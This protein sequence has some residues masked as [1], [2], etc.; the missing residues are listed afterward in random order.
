MAY[1]LEFCPYTVPFPIPL[2]THYGAWTVREGIFLRL[3]SE[4]G[5]VGLGEIAPLPDFGSETVAQ[6]LEFCALAPQEIT[7]AW[8]EQIP[9]GLPATQ[10]GVDQARLSVESFPSFRTT[11]FA[12]AQLL[13]AGSAL[14][15]QL[16][17]VQGQPHATWKWKI[18]VYPLQTELALLQAWG[19]AL[20]NHGVPPVTLRLDANGGLSIVEAQAWLEICDR[21]NG[22]HGDGTGRLRIEFLEQ[23]LPPHQFHELQAL[24]QSY[25]TPIALDE[26]VANLRSF[27]TVIE[28]GWSGLLVIKPAIMGRLSTLMS[29][30]LPHRDRLILS[31]VFE[32]AIGRWGL[33]YLAANLGL[34]NY[35][36]GLGV[37]RWRPV[38]NLLDRPGL[39][40]CW[41]GAQAEHQKT[42]NKPSNI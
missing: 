36:L 7:D 5:Q 26:S 21:I 10:F 18:A 4:S 1:Q 31:S 42:L 19:Q 15:D 11:D 39:E 20:I 27:Q 34:R 3:V 9:H 33:L 29:L 41:Q 8:F 17:Q 2:A 22:A 23:P 25:K 24:S 14:L 12:I 30:L 35:A 13:P 28:A 40:L 6:A 38:P 16:P 37:N 32:G